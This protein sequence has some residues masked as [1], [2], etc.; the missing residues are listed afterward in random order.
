MDIDHAKR[1]AKALKRELMKNGT[2]ITHCRALDLVAQSQGYK[3]GN[4]Y[5]ALAKRN[6][7]DF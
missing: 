1:Q 7:T 2:E 3:Y 5:V 6:Q 4:I